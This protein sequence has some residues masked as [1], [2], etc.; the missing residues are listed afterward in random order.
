M[1]HSAV[2]VM[3]VTLALFVRACQ[4]APDLPRDAKSRAEALSRLASTPE[5]ARLWKDAAEN[6][7][8]QG[9]E[10]V[11]IVERPV[12][13]RRQVVVAN[14]PVVAVQPSGLPEG[15]VAGVRV[16]AAP[17]LDEG[18]F[19]GRVRIRAVDGERL[20]VE[21]DP[22]RILTIFARARGGPLRVRAGDSAQLH[23][24]SSYNPL[25]R[26]QIVALRI[27]TGDYILSALE[28]G[29]GPVTVQVPL[30]KFV[31][32]Q[33]GRPTAGTMDV[34]VQIRGERRVLAQ[35]R[36]VEFG[37]ARASV[38]IMSSLAAPVSDGNPYALRV[39]AWASR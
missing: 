14:K 23:Y 26:R 3:A 10:K 37:V 9:L 11:P 8:A 6:N 13:P 15:L 29:R 34:E 20:E 4:R 32:T 31:A 38:G 27:D 5:Q 19:T 30:L 28:T 24:S 22:R 39:V 1:R 36:I 16:V 35:G 18:T 12:Q 21:V 2:L 25:D 33:V 7:K 17:G